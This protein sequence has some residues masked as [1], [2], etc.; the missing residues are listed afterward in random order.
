MD[1][2]FDKIDEKT[3]I[4]I[5]GRL[6][7]SNYEEASTKINKQIQNGE[8]NFIANLEKMDY[9]SSSGL[10][11]F[12]SVLKELKAVGGNIIICCIQPKIKEVFEISGFNTLF[13]ITQNLEEAKNK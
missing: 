10:R 5:I 6:D 4:S 11:V 8:R 1:I 9:I 12:L 2:T 3:I 7:T 13:T